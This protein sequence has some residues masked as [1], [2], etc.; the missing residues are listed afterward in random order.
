[1][2]KIS[3]VLIL[4]PSSFS[5]VLPYF[6]GINVPFPSSIWFSLSLYLFQQQQSLERLGKR[7]RIWSTC[8]LKRS[9]RNGVW[10]LFTSFQLLLPNKSSETLL[11][12]KI[13]SHSKETTLVLE[14]LFQLVSSSSTVDP[15][16]T[17]GIE[18]PPPPT[19]R[20]VKIRV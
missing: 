17:Q 9:K 13:M 5:S 10:T 3:L 7:K 14:F 8:L 19:P 16:A 15:W 2:V 18:T 6:W 4:F 11:K 12:K 20:A 1:M